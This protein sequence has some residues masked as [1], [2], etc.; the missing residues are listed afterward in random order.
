MKKR[1]HLA[2]IGV[3]V[4]VFLANIP[5]YAEDVRGVTGDTIKIGFIMDQTGP[6]ADTSL[7]ITAGVRNYFRWISDQGGIQGRRIKV[8]VEDDR[9]SIPMALAAFKKLV[10]KD[11]VLAILALGG[12]GQTKVLYHHMEKEKVPGITVGLTE[13]MVKP[14]KR[15]LFIPCAT[16]EDEVKVI[17]KYI[18][19]ELR[20]KD[21]RLGFITMNIEYGKVGWEAAVETAES[22]GLKIVDKEIVNFGAADAVSQVLG[23]KKKNANIVILHQ[24]IG[25]ALVF[26]KSAKKLGFT[27]TF[28]GTYYVTDDTV[29]R[30]A[31]EA[32][33]PLIG[34]HSLASWHEDTPGMV[35]VREI[36]LKYDPSFKEAMQNKFYTQGW[37]TALITAEG[38]KKAA[39]NLTIE[40]LVDGIESLK[41]LDTGGITAPIS[42]SKTSHKP[43]NYC[44]MYRSDVPNK[45]MIPTSG[46]LR[47]KE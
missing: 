14:Y 9:Y 46:W 42:Y 24:D 23:L 19:E 18:V 33:R 6:I 26:L 35:K 17:F 28:I 36:T 7:P 41:N 44:K 3:F 32:A 13:D 38:M 43:G 10:Y 12:T 11:K 34:V 5:S 4:L 20:T 37:I 45:K 15:Y 21:L 39:H 25:T 30:I 2:R 47:P 31:G 8:L 22:Y 29:V 40:G 16:Y 27:G 1:D